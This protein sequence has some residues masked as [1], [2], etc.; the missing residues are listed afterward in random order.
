MKI[1]DLEE[2]NEKLKKEKKDKKN[3]PKAPATKR[4]DNAVKSSGE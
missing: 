2:K 4:E 1:I 3:T